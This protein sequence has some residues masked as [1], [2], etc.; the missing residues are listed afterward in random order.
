[1]GG[2]GGYW[3][4]IIMSAIY[5]PFLI[6]TNDLRYFSF[7]NA[8]LKWLGTFLVTVFCFNHKQWRGEWFLYSLGI[9]TATLDI[10]YIFIIYQM[11]KKANVQFG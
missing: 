10:I 8:V 5:I 4:N 11:K 9:A 3:C 7:T 2:Y 6:R 1:M